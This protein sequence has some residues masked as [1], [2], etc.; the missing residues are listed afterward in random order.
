MDLRA[1]D[2][3]SK[4]IYRTSP[5]KRAKL[6]IPQYIT[7]LDS[8]KVTRN[9]TMRSCLTLAQ[10]QERYILFEEDP[11]VLILYTSGSFGCSRVDMG[12]YTTYPGSL[13]EK[14]RSYR[15]LCDEKYTMQ[16]K[17]GDEWLYTPISVFKKRVRYRIKEHQKVMPSSNMSLATVIEIAK[18]IQD[19]YYNYEAFIIL[20][21]TDTLSWIAPI[22]SFMLENLKKTVIIT[23][24]LIPLSEPR[25][26]ASNNLVTALTI[27]GHYWIPEVCVLFGNALY[28]GNRIVKDGTSA[29]NLIKSHN[30]RPLATIGSHFKIDWDS[31]L[32]SNTKKPFNVSFSL[33][34]NVTSREVSPFMSFADLNSDF[35]EGMKGKFSTKS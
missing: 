9:E 14:I 22:L 2:P 12:G 29:L 26:D 30:F 32:Y 4:V 27:A 5:I 34:T 25:N 28:R 7:P 10:I 21:G 19:D 1:P 11:R 23:S 13:E 16:N 31:I 15:I 3:S 24:C 20:H 33:D 35:V 6:D 17:A 8:D 18:M